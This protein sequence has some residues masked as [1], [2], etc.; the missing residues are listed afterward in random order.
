MT[1]IE[2]AK[3]APKSERLAATV[4]ETEARD[5]E[6]VILA[7]L[8]TVLRSAFEDV[9]TA[10]GWI[11]KDTGGAKAAQDAVNSICI[12]EEYVEELLRLARRP[13]AKDPTAH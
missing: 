5:R 9:S 8:G 7:Y 3:E 2:L 13:V 12:A 10:Q 1:T 11:P 4:Q 6:G